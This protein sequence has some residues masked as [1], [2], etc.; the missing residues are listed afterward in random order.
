MSGMAVCIFPVLLCLAF[1]ASPAKASMGYDVTAQ[2]G[3]SSL[4]IHRST[5]DFLLDVKGVV[6]GTGTF[7]RFNSINGFVGVS[8]DERTSTVKQSQ[9]EYGEQTLLRS[10][11][12]PVKFTVSMKSGTNTSLNESEIVVNDSATIEIDEKWPV[13]FASSKKIKY[14]GRGLNNRELYENNGDVVA[15]SVQSWK[16]SKESVY[17][18]QGNRSLIVASLTPQSSKVIRYMNRTSIYRLNMDSAGTLTSLQISR[19][20]PSHNTTLYLSQDYR[21]KQTITLKVGMNQSLLRPDEDDDDIALPCC[22]F[23]Y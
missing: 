2:V 1:L 19:H 7:S 17:M 6:K 16:L 5:M 14:T 13:Y 15:S 12:G 4:D 20:D 9:I 21:G 11:E 23:D 18:A 3:S 22:N 8:A 10:R